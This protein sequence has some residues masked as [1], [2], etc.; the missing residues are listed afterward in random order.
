LRVAV[1]LLAAKPGF[2]GGIGSYI[3]QLAG[4]LSKTAP[5]RYGFF[6]PARLAE[7][8]RRELLASAII[9][10]CSIDNRLPEVRALYEMIRLPKLAS[11]NDCQVIHYPH[12]LAPFAKSPTPVVTIHDILHVSQPANFSWHKR[13]YLDFTYRRLARGDTAIITD[14]EF[15]RGQLHELL[16]VPLSRV[17]TIPLGVDD[18]F[19]EKRSGG[20]IPDFPSEYL[21]SV[22]AAYRHKRLPVLVE[23]FELLAARHP[24]L[25]LVLAGTTV[26]DAK[27]QRRVWGL[28]A[29]SR[30]SS[31]I[32]VMDRVDA[33]L[34]PELFRS[35]RALVH[36]SAFEGFGLPLAEGMAA[37][38]PIVASPAPAVVEVLGGCG[39]LAEGWGAEHLAD[40]IEETLSWS[41]AERETRGTCAREM[42]ERYRWPK[43]VA[44]LEDHYESIE[45]GRDALKEHLC[46]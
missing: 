27:E 33:T 14:T 32:K 46:E 3:R 37:G 45:R 28:A 12:T 38:V 18:A 36:S 20:E 2:G 35:S 1:S 44:A 29:N 7:E 26:G 15:S 4:A 13:A 31:R 5:E 8:W 41:T 11:R 42:A 19:F 21:L 6:V 34:L 9:I 24:D 39:K 16:G 10:P 23:A 17:R 30:V 40:A 43:V 25:F 22:A